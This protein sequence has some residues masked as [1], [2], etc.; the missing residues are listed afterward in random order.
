MPEIV[1]KHVAGKGIR[2]ASLRKIRCALSAGKTRNADGIVAKKSAGEIVEIQTG[3]SG[4]PR[5]REVRR[6]RFLVA[7]VARLG[8]R[9]HSPH[10]RRGEVRCRR[11]EVA[12]AGREPDEAGLIEPR[13]TR[14]TRKQF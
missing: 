10:L 13:N 5:R 8:H 1:G 12:Q 6:G 9:A 2:P 11:A 3:K 14:N 7:D 4:R